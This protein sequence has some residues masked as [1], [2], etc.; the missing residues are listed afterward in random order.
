MENEKNEEKTYE[1]YLFDACEWVDYNTIRALE[2][3][4]KDYRPLIIYEV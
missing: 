4:N 3:C 1:D 2:Y